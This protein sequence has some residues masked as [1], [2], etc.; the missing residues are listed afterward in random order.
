MQI[1]KT[2]VNMYEQFM[3]NAYQLNTQHSSHNIN[4]AFC[5]AILTFNISEMF[6]TPVMCT[7][8]TVTMVSF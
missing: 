1:H 4:I 2:H 7:Y 6:I 8:S 5:T 3:N